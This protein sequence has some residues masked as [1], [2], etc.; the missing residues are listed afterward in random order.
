[1]RR[2]KALLIAFLLC[3][4][5][6]GVYF[7]P[8]LIK[9]LNHGQSQAGLETLSG[10]TVMWLAA[11]RDWKRHPLLGYGGGVGGKHVLS[12]VWGGGTSHLSH[13][14]DGFLE[15]LTGLGIFGFLLACSILVVLTL[16]VGRQWKKYPSLAGLYI[17]IISI[18]ITNIMSIGI[19]SWMNSGVVIYLVLLA[20]VDILR[21]G[22]PGAGDAPRSW[23]LA[24]QID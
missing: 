12:S 23:E 11:W 13:L 10:R 22:V 3:V 19:M 18:W 2:S 15:C 8:N 21:R 9:R 6:A 16:R 1:M 20:H 4:C 24:R 14:H 7:G 5:P 17:W